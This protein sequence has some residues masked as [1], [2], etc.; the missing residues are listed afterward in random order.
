MKILN[1]LDISMRCRQ[2]PT[3]AC[4][5]QSKK[6]YLC[7]IEDGPFVA[8]LDLYFMGG[9]RDRD[10]IPSPRT[11]DAI[12]GLK[13]REIACWFDDDFRALDAYCLWKATGKL[14][15]TPRLCREFRK[16]WCRYYV[17]LMP[18]HIKRRPVWMGGF[19]KWKGV[20]VGWSKQWGIRP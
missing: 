7:P 13:C 15:M 17:R 20:S 6:S 1:K 2:N 19:G 5:G 8:L 9:Y 14:E 12:P 18:L 16:A 4:P 3:Y 11:P 10:D